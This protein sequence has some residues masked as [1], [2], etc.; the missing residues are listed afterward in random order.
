MK[1]WIGEN[2]YPLHNFPKC[3]RCG[4]YILGRKKKLNPSSGWLH[5]TCAEEYQKLLESFK[6]SASF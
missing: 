2:W 6:H 4:C 3:Q 5:K 1:I